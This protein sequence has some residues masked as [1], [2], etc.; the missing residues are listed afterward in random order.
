MGKLNWGKTACA[1]VLLCAAAAI[2]TPA[3][4]FTRLTN[5]N[6]ANGAVP[7]LMSLVQGMDGNLYGTT[8]SG[9]PGS[10]G[11]VFKMTG[12]G[13][14]TTLYSFCA[15]SNCFD[16]RYPNAGLVLST[17]GNLYGTTSS[18]GTGSAGTVFK[19][20]P[21][22]RLTT[23]YSFCAQTDC[24]DGNDPNAGLVLGTDGNFYGTTEYGGL[25][26]GS[27]FKVTPSGTLT[28]LH[29]FDYTDGA[30]P[31]GGLVQAADGSFYG[32]T[33]GGGTSTLCP[34]PGGCGTVFR[35]T[36]RGTLTALHNFD[37]NDGASPYAGLVQGT[38]RS[39]YGTTTGGG[40]GDCVG[41]CGTVF[42]I[43]L[44][45]ALTT[46]HSFDVAD[47]ANP[48]AGLVQGTDGNFYGTTTFGGNVTC[49]FGCGTV[50][51]IT[52]EGT[53]TTLHSFDPS[54]GDRP[55][56]GLVQATNGTFYGTTYN[57]GTYDEGTVFS[58][59][60]GLG[61]FVEAQ[62]TSGKVGKA[63]KILGTNL[64]GATRV[65]FNGTPAV[66][67]LVLSSYITTTVPPGAITG[68]LKVVTPKRTLSSNVAFRVLP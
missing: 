12:A 65:S 1:V 45:G 17:D 42:K 23:L 19:M 8:S 4:T 28:T 50:F 24:T 7:Y 49:P 51:T 22:G 20:T 10:A 11:T 5:F 41:G 64:T 52:R 30:Y 44:G 55:Y 43:T 62:P 9:G 21:A 46:L 61:P 68:K 16:G 14:L 57:G 3:R 40:G 54:D 59:F 37:W 18:G 53:L 47:G 39:F 63:V 15:Q 2:A 27:V 6:G 31:V 26:Y 33:A 25:Y 38:D 29:I 36:P 48:Y 13:K 58:L 32:T 56:S 66:F 35:I 67:K 34:D 60:V